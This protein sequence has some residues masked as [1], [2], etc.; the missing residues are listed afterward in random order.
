[1]CALPYP[2]EHNKYGIYNFSLILI[3]LEFMNVKSS[4]SSKKI[5]IKMS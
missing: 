3:G 2:R 5:S 1:M 4:L